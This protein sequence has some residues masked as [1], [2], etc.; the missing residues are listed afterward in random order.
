MGSLHLAAI[1]DLL[2]ARY[3][4]PARVPAAAVLD[5][6]RVQPGDLFVATR[7]ARVDGH[8]YV[9]AAATRGAVAAL[10]ERP[11][12][13]S[14]PCLPVR[15]S[16]AALTELGRANREAFPGVV[17][18][19]TGS[20]GKTSVKNMCRAIF[21]RAGPTVATEG[22]Y[23]NEIGVPLTLTRL[24]DD[25]QFAIVEMGATG[26]GHVAHLCELARPQISTVLNAME[27][28]L[29]GFGSVDDVAD[30][31]AE[32]YDGLAAGDVAVVNL[33]SPYASLWRERIAATGSR[34][35]TYSCGGDADV[36]GERCPRRRPEGHALHA[37]Y[38]HRESQPVS[39]AAGPA[40]GLQRA[41][42]GGA[43]DGRRRRSGHDRRGPRARAA[44]GRTPAAR[45][46]CRRH[47]AH[48]R[49]LQRQPG[50]GAGG[51]R[52][53]R[54]CAGSPHPGAGRDARTR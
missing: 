35:V 2:G 16:L 8:D 51:D 19:I 36:R 24:G 32:I 29:Q 9:E 44:R 41:G 46:A 49:Q 22:N 5:S 39:A 43:R 42:R 12:D 47:A 11:M 28:H 50:I 13:A 53:S 21:E 54:R 1:A 52:S 30:I 7:G 20:C 45:N 33:D 14:I 10:T 25:T 23:N 31:K 26:R 3:D 6:R 38:R 4:G 40:P 15:D 18:S 34:V 48:R 27:A 17:L 37:A